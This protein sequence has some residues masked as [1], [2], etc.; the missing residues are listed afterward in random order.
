MMKGLTC[1]RQLYQ[2]FMVQVWSENVHMGNHQSDIAILNTH[3]NKH[4]A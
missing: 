1:A 3:V 2:Y 4:T